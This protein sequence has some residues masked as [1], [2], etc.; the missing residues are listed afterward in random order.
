MSTSGNTSRTRAATQITKFIES[1]EASD[2]FSREIYWALRD[3]QNTCHTRM[4]RYLVVG[5]SAALL[6]ELLNR[7]LI[8]G[9]SFSTV[10]LSRLGFLRYILPVAFSFEIMLYFFAVT[11]LQAYIKVTGVFTALRFPA[12]SDSEIDFVLAKDPFLTRL[13]P[14]SY[15]SKRLQN[16][17]MLAGIPQAMLLT[18][19]PIAFL[20]YAYFQLF[21]HFPTDNPGPWLSLFVS[22]ILAGSGYATLIVRLIEQS[23]F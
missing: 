7:G 2:E 15:M 23:K 8:S 17:E 1:N 18:T 10:T 14:D 20:I 3:E 19:G 12:L 5:F 4:G 6:F 11:E 13:L 21:V 22:V 9:A 16:A